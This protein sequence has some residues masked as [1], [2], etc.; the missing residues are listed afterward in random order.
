M[1]KSYPF[2]RAE[3]RIPMTIAVR[4]GS[5]EYRSTETTFTRNVSSRGA[6]VLTSHSWQIDSKVRVA[7]MPGDFSARGRVAYC[8]QLA[9]ESRTFV[10]GV[11]FLEPSGKWVVGHAASA[12]EK[13]LNG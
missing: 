1:E 11:E 7:S 13:I 10:I 2:Y 9:M 12:P 6:Q 3:R 5:E 4:L 8:E